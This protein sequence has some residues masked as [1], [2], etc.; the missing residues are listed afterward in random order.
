MKRLMFIA[1]VCAFVAVPV[2]ADLFSEDFESG[3]GAW[4]GFSGQIVANPIGAGNTLNF[5]SVYAGGDTFTSVGIALTPGQSYSVSF[6]YLGVPGQGTP[7]DLGG[8]AGL[9]E[10]TTPGNPGSH[11]WYYGTGSVSGAAAVLVDDGAWHRYT[12]N[13][14]APVV[15]NAGS[16]SVIHLMFEDFS[17][18]GGVA[19]DAYFDNI[20]L[21]P[22]PGAVLLGILGLSA[23]GIKL[24]KFA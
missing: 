10:G 3:L 5:R 21:V 16:F 11:M 23:A 22:V 9:S 14:T 7:G 19:G 12:Y 13:F 24:R 20:S 4:T 1:I 18:S 6:D 2:R 8:Y 15:G 17:G